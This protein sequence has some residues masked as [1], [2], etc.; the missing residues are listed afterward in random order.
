MDED[1]EGEGEG[2]MD[3]DTEAIR[4]A[5]LSDPLPGEAGEDVEMGEEQ[6]HSGP[7]PTDDIPIGPELDIPGGQERLE[8]GDAAMADITVSVPTASSDEQENGDSTPTPGD[9]VP[10][11]IHV[12][13]DGDAVPVHIPDAARIDTDMPV[14]DASTT[15]DRAVA[16]PTVIEEVTSATI[17][18]GPGNERIPSGDLESGSTAPPDANVE[19]GP[20]ANETTITGDANATDEL[21]PVAVVDARTDDDGA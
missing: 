11:T 2:D 9:F 17:E 16:E 12:E 7:G 20:P 18:A 4:A 5:I 10:E 14:D 1:D 21:A 13:A 3:M 19:I 8:T 15:P 6:P